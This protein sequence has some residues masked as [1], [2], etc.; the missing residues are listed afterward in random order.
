MK[1]SSGRSLA[2]QLKRMTPDWRSNTQS[3]A[4]STS[5]RIGSSHGTFS[6]LITETSCSIAN[7]IPAIESGIKTQVPCCT[8]EVLAT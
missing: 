5:V 3:A 8:I 2:K 6:T 1:A 4:L 7:T